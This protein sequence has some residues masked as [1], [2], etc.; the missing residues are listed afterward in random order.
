MHCN[1]QGREANFLP[2]GK[3]EFKND[4]NYTYTPLYIFMGRI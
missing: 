4:W 2:A 1:W 3:A